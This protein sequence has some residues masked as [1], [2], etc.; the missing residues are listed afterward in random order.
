MT[1]STAPVTV[2][3][4]SQL[5]TIACYTTL[6]GQ[7]ALGTIASA[8]TEILVFDYTNPAGTNAIPAKNLIIRGVNISTVNLGVVG[9][10][11]GVVQ[12]WSL[13]VGGTTSTLAAVDSATA[14]TRAFRKVPLGF[15]VFPASAAI[16]A[17]CVTPLD[18][19]LDA[20]IVV[21]PGTHVAIIMKSIAGPSNVGQITRGTCFVNGYFE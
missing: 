10:A 19:N 12:Q 18:I 6:G 9:S 14:G 2:A 16:G 20:P 8:E 13:G 21:E 1:L 15:T 4:A 3:A 17:P 5:S 11:L 7:F